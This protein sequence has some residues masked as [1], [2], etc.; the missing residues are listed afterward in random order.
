MG[1]GFA[2]GGPVDWMCGRLGVGRHVVCV[3]VVLDRDDVDR[4]RDVLH[5]VVVPL[6]IALVLVVPFV[7][8]ARAAMNAAALVVGVKQR[9]NI[10][11]EMG[12][13]AALGLGDDGGRLGARSGDVGI[14]GGA[15]SSGGDGGVA[16]ALRW[17]G[18]IYHGKGLMPWK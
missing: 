2:R 16:P 14:E 9:R 12:P 8:G 18:W 1:G 5:G 3:G 6:L 10:F 13:G 17:G 7:A 11:L 4:R 15:T